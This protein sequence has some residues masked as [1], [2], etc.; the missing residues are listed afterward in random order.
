MEVTNLSRNPSNAMSGCG[1][2]FFESPCPAR[3][4]A[5]GEVRQQ[6]SVAY[7]F[8]RDQTDPFY[9]QVRIVPQFAYR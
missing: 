5:A 1:V 3:S 2:A 7:P 8:V 4:K 6:A 9:L